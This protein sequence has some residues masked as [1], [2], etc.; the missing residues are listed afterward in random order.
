MEEARTLRVAIAQPSVV[1]TLRNA[2]PPEQVQAALIVGL[3]A[4]FLGGGAVEI[5]LEGARVNAEQQVAGFHRL[6]VDNGQLH[7]R[8]GN[9]RGNLDDVGPY[10]AVSRPGVVDVV[11]V[12]PARQKGGYKNNG[13][14]RYVFHD[15]L[16]HVGNTVEPSSTV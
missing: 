10:H 3:G 4:N 2:V 5:F 12:L 11:P 14:G 9:A 6:V 8:P 16:A 7:D 1:K 15:S 13:G